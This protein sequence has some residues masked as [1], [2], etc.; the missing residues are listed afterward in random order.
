MSSRYR[1]SCQSV[2][3]AFAERDFPQP[4]TPTSRIPRGGEMRVFE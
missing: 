1:G 2:A 4:G 3:I